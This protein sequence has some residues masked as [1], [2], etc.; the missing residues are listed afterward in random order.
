MHRRILLFIV[1][2]IALSSQFVGSTQQVIPANATNSTD[3]SQSHQQLPSPH[4]D[5]GIHV[6]PYTN[7][8]VGLVDSLRMP[9]VKLYTPDQIPRFPGK[10]VLFR[11]DVTWTSYSSNAENFRRDIQGRVRELSDLGVVAIEVH[12]E[13]NLGS[14]W[15]NDP[16][17]WE[18]TQ[19][20]RVVY[21][22]IKRINPTIIVVSGG[23]APTFTTPNGRSVNDL[24]FAE[25]MFNN[26][27]GNFF[28]VF[29]YHPYGYNAPPEQAPSH[30]LLNFRRVELIHEL[31][32]EHNINKQIWLTEFGW[33]RD[34]SED[35]VSC[36]S[37]DPNIAD[38]IW[39][40]VDGRTQADYIVR[41]FAYADR[42]WSWAGPTFLWNL[43]W[44]MIPSNA[45]HPCSHMRWFALLRGD[46]RPTQAFNSV[47]T[48]PRRPAP[49]I[50]GQIPNIGPEMVL[51]ADDM[52]VEVGVTCLGW[53]PVGQFEVTNEGSGTFIVN[54]E[55]AISLSGPAVEVS[56][57]VA[58]IDDVVTIFVDTT[59]LIAG[60]YT[61]HINVSTTIDERIIRQTV[62]GY[63]HISESYAAC[64]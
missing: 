18:Y 36:S 60:L 25:D 55:P 30:D 19:I 14:E 43:N 9:W 63:I 4:L 1:F 64:Q 2:S 13:P 3:L 48:M 38:F 20:L 33:L 51:V 49:W 8:D 54:I 34:P 53:V 39:M 21:T 44:S 46:G 15:N 32:R 40:L 41:A 42:N 52:T 45:L 7:V 26:N 29:G 61:V 59:G 56:P 47:A 10:R 28:D 37:S 58:K 17:A 50:P 62:Q 16:N 57:E 6:A 5:Y 24:D 11:L 22:E 27:A 23:L 12:N 35:G 31:M